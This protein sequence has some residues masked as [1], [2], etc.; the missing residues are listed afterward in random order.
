[1]HAG[2]AGLVDLEGTEKVLAFLNGSL[3]RLRSR[4]ERSSCLERDSEAEE[5]RKLRCSS[6][7]SDEK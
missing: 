5:R 4:A 7:G 2:N 3:R 6:A 1:V